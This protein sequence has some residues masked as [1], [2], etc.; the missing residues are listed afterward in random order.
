V[1]HTMYRDLKP[2]LVLYCLRHSSHNVCLQHSCT[3][4][5]SA[6]A[7]SGSVNASVHITAG[8]CQILL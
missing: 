8:V 7:S 6:P 2:L 3:T 4:S 5:R 1:G